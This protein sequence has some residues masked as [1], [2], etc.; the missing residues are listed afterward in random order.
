MRSIGPTGLFGHYL[1]QTRGLTRGEEHAIA[2]MPMLLGTAAA[3]IGIAGAWLAYV[4]SP[5]LPRRL[6]QAWQT[7]Y[8]WSLN[9]FY[10]DE[11]FVALVVRPLQG[12]AWLCRVLDDY[13]IDFLV[14][15]AGRVPVMLGGLLRPVQNGQVQSYA[16]VMVL[17][18]AALLLAVLNAWAGW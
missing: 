6:A 15:A 14:D 11:I 10:W 7:A 9:K 4:G 13:L 17:G 1:A 5:G 8:N 18:L 3:L 16:L 12:L 2:W